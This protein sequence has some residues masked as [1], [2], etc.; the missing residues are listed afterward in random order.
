MVDDILVIGTGSIGKRHIQCLRDLGVTRISICDPNKASLDSTSSLYNIG[1]AY[2]D[3]DDA[4]KH[5]YGA[6]IVAVPNH[7]HADISCKVIEKKWM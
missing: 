4:L 2:S 6:V 1:K 3:V 5:K 7:I